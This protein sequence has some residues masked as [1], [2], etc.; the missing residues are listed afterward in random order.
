MRQFLPGSTI[1]ISA[2]SSDETEA[3]LDHLFM[4]GGLVMSQVSLLTGLEP[5]MI[6]NWVKRGFLTP[7]QKKRYDR[8]QFCRI[9]TINMLRESLQ[10]DSIVHLLSYV[11]GVLNDHSDDRIADSRLY[12]LFVELLGC[13]P[14]DIS[15]DRIHEAALILTD[16]T[17]LPLESRRRVASA[18]TGMALAYFAARYRTLADVWLRS[19]DIE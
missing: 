7:P 5:Y 19:L 15:R 3:L 11:N 6:Q 16:G 12:A 4:T 17:D 14:T 1:E 18:L 9:L 13:I 10:I 2:F 8:D